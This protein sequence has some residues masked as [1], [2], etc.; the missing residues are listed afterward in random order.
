MNK[1]LKQLLVFSILFFN[2]ILLILVVSKV[3]TANSFKYKIDPKKNILILGDSH[4][5]CGLNDIEMKNMLNLSESAD[6]YFYSYVKLKKLVANNRQIDTLILGYANHNISKAQDQ[7]LKSSNINSFKLPIHFFLFDNTDLK[8]FVKIAP[9]VFFEN[10]P[11]IIKTNITH[12]I[13][14]HKKEPINKFG[15]GGYLSLNK[16]L[17]SVPTRDKKVE[18]R[19]QSY[20]KTDID[21][22]KEIYALCLRHNIKLILLNTPV[23][24]PEKIRS[25]NLNYTLFANKMFKRA[26][27]IDY[28]KM[29][30]DEKYFADETHLNNNGSTLFSKILIKDLKKY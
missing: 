2:L 5:Q 26:T 24:S 1:F 16:I 10:I 25:G 15:I 18:V 7:W 3:F 29:K 8:N 11:K 9:Y 22:L 20:S 4:T 14:I 23:Y 6:T 19:N 17:N 12:V 13:R 27:L 21:F 28:S 30:F